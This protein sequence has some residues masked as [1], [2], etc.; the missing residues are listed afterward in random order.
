MS[1]KLIFIFLFSGVRFIQGD[2]APYYPSPFPIDGLFLI[3]AEA[4][5]DLEELKKSLLLELGGANIKI[6]RI[7]EA[8]PVLLANF[9]KKYMDKVLNIPGV[10]YVEDDAAVELQAGGKKF[11]EPVLPEWNLDRIN[12]RTL[13]LDGNADY[14]GNGGKDVHIYL[15]DTGIYK[16][17][18]EFQGKEIISFDFKAGG[19]G[20]DC[21]GHGTHVAAIAV[22]KKYGVAKNATVHGVKICGCRGHSTKGHVTKGI[23]WI[24][25][26]RRLPCVVQFGIA[27]DEGGSPTLD[28][29]VKELTD[30]DCVVVAPAGNN[31][32]D[33]CLVSPARSQE[34]ITVGAL[35][36]FD[37]IHHNSN[38]GKCIDI[39]APGQSIMSAWYI[40]TYD[41][42][43][44][45]G[46]SMSAGH[47]TGAVALKLSSGMKAD[48]VKAKLIKESTKS[49][50]H[51]RLNG[52]P[53]RML[54]VKPPQDKVKSK[55]KAHGGNVK[56]EEL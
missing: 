54:Y 28:N 36:K 7:L 56:K 12:Q 9:D 15:L 43:T 17:H 5:Q 2:P 55:P 24:T 3:G 38:W 47:V 34:A 4:D 1:Y 22:G 49:K 42:D 13:P 37:Y 19:N 44:L 26:K 18:E 46:T 10:A 53:S 25:R 27:S 16:G 45:S 40:S 39:F 31:G 35:A 41:N 48:K 30:L 23:N 32:N 51:G 14:A 20:I 8:P 11:E 33:S 6:S 50:M 29:G 52:S 21:N